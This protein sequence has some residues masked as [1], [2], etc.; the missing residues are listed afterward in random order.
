[1]VLLLCLIF[2]EMHRFQNI[3][4]WEAEK[5]HLLG[6]FQNGRNS[7]AQL[8]IGPDGGGALPLALAYAGLLVCEQP[9]A[10]GACGVC[11]ACIQT[12]KGTHPDVHC[13]VP[14][15]KSGATGTSEE[16]LPAW[17][18]AVEQF[19]F[20]TYGRWL[21]QAGFDQKQALI[22]VS[23]S[24]RI[25]KVAALRSFSGGA[26]V[27]LLWM[28]E[29]MNINAANK[30]LKILEEPERG[31]YFIL[32]SHQPEQLLMTIRSRCQMVTTG[33]L[34]IALLGEWLHRQGHAQHAGEQ[35]ALLARGIPGTALEILEAADALVAHAE[36]A[37]AWFR[38]TFKGEWATLVGWADAMGAEG[39][40]NIKAFLNFLSDFTGRL[41]PVKYPG[42][43]LD[44][45]ALMQ[46]AG[47][48]PD[49][50]AGMITPHKASELLREIDR[51]TSDIERNVQPKVV[52][53]DL[54][55]QAH[56]ILRKKG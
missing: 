24:E 13:V 37:V 1:L 30:L 7:H 29:K 47:F 38:H 44:F 2:A 36:N 45:P 43:G 46:V 22:A 31:T 25:L 51:A 8:F 39:R 3:P 12:A 6:A 49:G 10:D 18:E 42:S 56:Q 11:S 9:V 33:P 52:M 54:S 23:E 20:L 4:G 15:V 19:P 28:P 55:F 27:I 40:E 21:Q 5:E 17:R 14:V 53:F 48:K 41:I 50:L 34:P 26:R 35:A 16:F 32:V